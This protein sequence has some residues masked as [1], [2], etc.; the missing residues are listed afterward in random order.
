MMTKIE[1]LGRN[2]W[3]WIC[4][5]LA[6]LVEAMSCSTIHGMFLG[7]CQPWITLSG[8]LLMF[9]TAFLLSWPVKK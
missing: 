3:I 1:F 4:I 9:V 5:A 6:V 2:L 8:C 7:M